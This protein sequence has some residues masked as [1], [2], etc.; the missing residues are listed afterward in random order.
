MHDAVTRPL[1][2]EPSSD[3]ERGR[4]MV[5][6]KI[7]PSSTVFRYA[8]DSDVKDSI[9][10]EIYVSLPHLRDSMKMLHMALGAAAQTRVFS[11]L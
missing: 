4:A 9:Y 2:E 10:G 8:K 11:H 7:D 5:G 1:F 3:S 6:P